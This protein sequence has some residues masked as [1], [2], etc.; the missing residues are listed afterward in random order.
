[1]S[2]SVEGMAPQQGHHL[3][4]ASAKE[5]SV[6]QEGSGLGSRPFVVVMIMPSG[7]KTKQS[8]IIREPLEEP[9]Y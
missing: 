5:K 7:P 8:Y 4:S 6:L 2:R 3:M 9:K 1:M